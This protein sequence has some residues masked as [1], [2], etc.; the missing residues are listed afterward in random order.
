MSLLSAKRGRHQQRNYYVLT[1]LREESG[2]GCDRPVMKRHQLDIQLIYMCNLEEGIEAEL[3]TEK[4]PRCN[5]WDELILI[6]FLPSVAVTASGFDRVPAGG[7]R[8]PRL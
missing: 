7:C 4:N 3:S 2:A 6:S 8:Q 1:E 5:T